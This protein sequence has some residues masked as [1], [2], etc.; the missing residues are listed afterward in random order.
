MTTLLDALNPL[1]RTE[2]ETGFGENLSEKAGGEIDEARTDGRESSQ[3][4]RR[5]KKRDEI[6][7]PATQNGRD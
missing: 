5:L 3:N 6:P 4:S 2:L 1:P 7:P